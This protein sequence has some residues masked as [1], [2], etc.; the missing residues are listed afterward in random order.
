MKLLQTFLSATFALA[1]IALAAPLTDTQDYVV[2]EKRNIVPR[3]WVRRGRLDGNYRL[4]MRIA[5]KQSNLDRLEEH[6]MTVSHPESMEY[7]HH[8]TPQKVAEAFAPSQETVDAVS[9]WLVQ[10]GVAIERQSRS[11]SQG[12]LTFEATVQEAE[13]LL[14]TEYSIWEHEDSQTPHVATTHYS[15]P[16]SV[17]EHVDFVMPTLHFDRK[18][19][20]KDKQKKR[21]LQKR[22]ATNSRWGPG[23][24]NLPKYQFNSGY[25]NIIECVIPFPTLHKAL[26]Y[27]C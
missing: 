23:S 12:W 17:S 26:F 25:E 4:P 11:G 27:F 18:L 19:P 21:D 5:L 15:L 14:R 1:A 10:A 8:W 20:S 9:N 16:A 13:R 3:G 7:G 24:T 22:D 6:L 2:H